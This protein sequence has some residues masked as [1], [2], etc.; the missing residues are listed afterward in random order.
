MTPEELARQIEPTAYRSWS[1][2]EVTL[3]DG[4]ELRYSDGFSRRGN[5]VFPAAASRLPHSEKLEWCRAW[6]SD[7]GLDLVVR[8]TIAT[9]PGLDAVLADAGF[10]I[11]GHTDVMTR[12]LAEGGDRSLSVQ[13]EPSADWFHTA[14]ALWGFDPDL[15]TGWRAII[16][17]I[18]R[19]AGFVCVPDK[20]AGL[21]IVD[22]PWVGLFEIIVAPEERRNGLGT[23]VTDSLLS[24][25]VVAGA[26]RSYLQVVADNDVA[27]EFYRRHGYQRSYEYWYR[28]DQTA[29]NSPA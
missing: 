28:R 10:T 9:E 19:P 12:A 26:V 2:R 25:G 3:Y 22:G 27:I 17:R 24:W 20:A 6:Y 18:V 14:A 16:E 4:W 23:A 8:Q 5:S 7:R 21:A 11:E 1:A 15:P 29:A 13:P